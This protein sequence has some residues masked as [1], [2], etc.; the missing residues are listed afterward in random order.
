MKPV[1]KEKRKSLEDVLKQIYRDFIK[2]KPKDKISNNKILLSVLEELLKRMRKCDDLFSSMKPV[3]K[4][5]GSYY[6]GLRVGKPNEYDINLKMKLPVNYKKIKLD[7]SLSRHDYTS[8]LMPSEFRRLSK[9][10]ATAEKGFFKTKQW[11]NNKYQLSV[12][13]FLSWMQSVVDAAIADLPIVQGRKIICVNNI[14]YQIST[15]IS[16][17]ANTITISSGP[18]YDN[19]IDIDLVPTFSFTLP[20]KPINSKVLFDIVDKTNIKEYF[21]VPKPSE[22]DYSWRLS[23]P[24]QE[25]ILMKQKNYFKITVKLLKLLRDVQGFKKLASYYIKSLFLFEIIE[26]GDAADI[27]WKNHSL[28]FLVM[29]MLKKLRD[30]LAKGEIKNVWCPENN[31][32]SGRIH[33]KTC[34]NW[35]NRL[36]NIINSIEANSKSNPSIVIRH[37]SQSV[38]CAK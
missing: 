7:A 36:T 32:L 17:P 28:S 29:Y 3:L 25:R 5:L 4:Y 16:G 31:L 37:F 2:I 24:I 35:S 20:Q 13:K 12:Q 21:V 27:F 22:N 19:V 6:D 8:I 9:T 26:Q 38:V 34:I 18:N 23:F 30:C 15:K 11:C 14:N 10:P 1:M 33:D